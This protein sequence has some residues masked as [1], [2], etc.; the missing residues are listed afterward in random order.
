[1]SHFFIHISK[2]SRNEGTGKDE[3]EQEEERIEMEEKS[4]EREERKGQV[5]RAVSKGRDIDKL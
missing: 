3:S 2:L 4:R 1:M 5:G